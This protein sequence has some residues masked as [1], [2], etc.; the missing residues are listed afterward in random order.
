MRFAAPHAV[1]QGIRSRTDAAIPD[2]RCALIL[3]LSEVFATERDCGRTGFRGAAIQVVKVNK[4]DTAG[5]DTATAYDGQGT[6]APADAFTLSG[7]D[8]NGIVTIMGTPFRAWNRE[9][10]TRQRSLHV[11]RN[12]QHQD[13]RHQGEG[14]RY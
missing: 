7:P 10:R 1:T 2:A 3:K 8:K 11:C 9:V 12:R 6:T 5:T 4:T 14:S 13:G